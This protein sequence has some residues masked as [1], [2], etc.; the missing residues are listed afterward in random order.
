MKILVSKFKIASDGMEPRTCTQVLGL[1]TILWY[2]TW[3]LTFSAALYFHS[4][5]FGIYIVLFNP[6]HL[7]TKVQV[8]LQIQI[9]TTKS[10]ST[11]MNNYVFKIKIKLPSSMLQF[12]NLLF[13]LLV[14]FNPSDI[15]VG[16][17]L[18]ETTEWWLQT[19][20]GGCIKAKSSSI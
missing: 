12:A 1:S 16:G 9:I 5:T 13:A 11:I 18:N 8:T 2:F 17:T 10:K 3:V 6:L 14:T 4:T 20:R 15:I 7:I 19:K